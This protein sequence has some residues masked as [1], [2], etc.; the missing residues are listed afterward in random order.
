MSYLLLLLIMALVMVTP[1]LAMTFYLAGRAMFWVIGVII[2]TLFTLAL[3][4]AIQ[5][6]AVLIAGYVL[7]RN[8]LKRARTK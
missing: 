4:I 6:V 3:F 1:E 2:Q 8:M 5:L 7:L